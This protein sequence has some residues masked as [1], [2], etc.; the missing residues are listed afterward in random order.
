[1]QAAELGLTISYQ[2]PALS[3]LHDW[4]RRQAEQSNY[5]T[6]G[7]YAGALGFGYNTELL[8]KKQLPAPACWKDLLKPIYKDEVQ[9]ANPNSSGTAY[10][11]IATLVQ[12]MGEDKA[13]DFLKELHR[14]VNQ[15]TRSGIGP[16]KAVARG[17]TTVSISMIHDGVTEATSGFAVKVTTPCEG[18]GYEIGSMSLIKGAKNLDNAKKWYEWSLSPEGQKIGP[19]NKQFQLPSNMKVALPEQAPKFSNIKL[20]DYNFAKYGSSAERK[21]LLARWDAEVGSLPK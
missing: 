12:I 15:Y 21:R 6:V 5:R 19:D 11:M 17:E 13:F 7:I 8:A 3:S 9:V 4:A 16:I 2:S 1:L 20:I 10:T 14:N 18:T